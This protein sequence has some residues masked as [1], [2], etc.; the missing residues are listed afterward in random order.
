MIGGDE[1]ERAGL[2]R[3]AE[4]LAMRGLADRRRTL[5][6]GGAVANLLGRERQVVR[7]RFGGDP[8][9]LRLRARDRVGTFPARDVDDVH[10]DAEFA[11][12]TNHDLDGG[13]L[14]L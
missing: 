2:Q 13:E 14:R 9:A 3:A 11:R 7:A 10:V 12:E 1:I 5:E 6:F 4:R 8:Y